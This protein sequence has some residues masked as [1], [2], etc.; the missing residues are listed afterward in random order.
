MLCLCVEKRRNKGIGQKIGKKLI[1]LLI[2]VHTCMHGRFNVDTFIN[3]F[4]SNETI[5]HDDFYRTEG[6]LF[7][8]TFVSVTR[9]TFGSTFSNS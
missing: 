8:R 9:W 3:L 5:R 6:Q 7:D 4:V 1:E 2:H